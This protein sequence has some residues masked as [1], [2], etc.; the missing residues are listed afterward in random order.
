MG[1]FHYI[2]IGFKNAYTK[3][4]QKGYPTKE[5][6]D[7]QNKINNKFQKIDNETREKIKNRTS[8]Y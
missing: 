6:W 2:W 4:I 7:I 3:N 1:V 8:I 5:L